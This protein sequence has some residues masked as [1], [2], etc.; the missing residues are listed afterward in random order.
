MNTKTKILALIL[1]IDFIFI[2]LIGQQTTNNA[3]PI[4]SPDSV[5]IVESELI[6]E[7]VDIIEETYISVEDIELLSLLTM[8]EAEGECEEGKILVIDTVLNRVDSDYFPDTIYDV[9]YQPNQFSSMW[10][11]RID[12]CEV[13][14][15]IYELVKNEMQTRTNNDV[16]FF[17]AGRYSKYGVPMFQVENHFFS[18]Y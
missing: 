8:A 18:S 12:R 1:V 16:I 9:I 17:T 5:I 15:D 3:D 14:E 7:P 10:N 6:E 13:R 2:V 11:G 4:F